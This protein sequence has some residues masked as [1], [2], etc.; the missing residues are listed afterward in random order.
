MSSIPLELLRSRGGFSRDARFASIVASPRHGAAPAVDPGIEAY[1][2]GFAEGLAQGEENAL[3][4]ERE[5][6]SR[7]AAIELAFARFDER[8][9][10]KLREGLRQTVHALCEEMIVPL[11]LEPE[12][13]ADRIEKAAGMLQRAQDDQCVL[14]NPEDLPLVEARVPAGLK[15]RGDETV[16]RGGLRIETEDGGVEDSP[17]QCGRILAEAFRE[18]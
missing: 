7:R 3:A 11:A 12:S 15:L 18:C 13:L 4:S 9:A 6:D 1:Q 10:G 8:C 5:R 16:E 14:L 2:R 17:T